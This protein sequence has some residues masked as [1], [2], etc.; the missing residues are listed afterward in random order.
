[1]A[2][3]AA[4]WD[5]LLTI[6]S[7]DNELLH[8]NFT[9]PLGAVRVPRRWVEIAIELN[10]M[11]GASKT[12]E[13]WKDSWIN[14]RGRA[15][16]ALRKQM[17]YLHG[18]GGGPEVDLA[19]LGL[20]PLYQRVINLTGFR[21]ALGTG[22]PNPLQIQLNLAQAAVAP[23]VPAV[24]AAPPVPAEA[25]A[26]PLPAVAVVPPVPAEAVAPPVPAVAVVAVA[27]PVPAVAVAPPVPRSFVGEASLIPLHSVSHDLSN[28]WASFIE[29]DQ[30][31]DDTIVIDDDND[32]L[33]GA[34]PPLVPKPEIKQ[35]EF[36]AS[37]GEEN[38][39]LCY[40]MPQGRNGNNKLQDTI[41]QVAAVS[42]HPRL[43]EQL[44]DIAHGNTMI[45]RNLIAVVSLLKED[46]T[47]PS[48]HNA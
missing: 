3:S 9:A 38:E 15:R 4:Q 21:A 26:P 10:A 48:D 19:G 2:P 13:K 14:L 7:N 40:P 43:E 39:S 34:A 28:E 33:V 12:G 25:A 8:C 32:V 35:E 5:R 11:G 41:E 31:K 30:W 42:R 29:L 46:L 17:N 37:D 18:T 44:C 6:L 22:C 27:P 20:S 16:D 47:L 23:P 24:A 36:A 1:M 45:M